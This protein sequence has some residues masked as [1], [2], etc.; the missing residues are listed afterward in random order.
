MFI[1]REVSPQRE[2]LATN[3][4]LIGRYTPINKHLHPNEFE[5]T[6]SS[7]QFHE[8]DSIFGFVVS[9]NGQD[10][11]ILRAGREYYVMTESGKTFERLINFN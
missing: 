4:E 8:P 7:G 2:G 5:R 10:T 1:L 9:N 6:L 3:T 11:Q